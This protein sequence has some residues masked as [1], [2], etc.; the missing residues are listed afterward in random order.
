MPANRAAENALGT[1]GTICWTLQLLPQIWYSYRTKSTEGLSEWLM[2]AW[3]MAGIFL[4]TYSVVQNLNIPLILQPQLF[5]VLSFVSWAQCQYYGRKRSKATAIAMYVAAV[6]IFAGFEVGMI[7]AIFPSYRAGNMAPVRFF[8]IFSTI[9]ISGALLPQ[10]YEI[11]KHKEVIGISLIF[12]SVDLLGGVFNDLS[13]AFK[14]EFDIVA[15]V[16][17]SLV[18]LLDGIVILCA[19]IL[20]P[21][22]RRRR[23]RLAAAESAASAD[24]VQAPVEPI[25]DLANEKPPEVSVSQSA[26]SGTVH[27]KEKSAEVR[28]REV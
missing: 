28:C 8:G 24:V 4:G 6:A 22:A 15:G 17:Y 2:F 13:L 20:N 9:L 21:L 14:D 7:F 18:V 10:Y 26:G 3:G 5:G 16:T 25:G 12:M 27:D 11:Y 19:F 23:K 1:I